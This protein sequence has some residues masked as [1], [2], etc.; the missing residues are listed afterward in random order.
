MSRTAQP[1]LQL[2]PKPSRTNMVCRILSR[3]HVR[4]VLRSLSSSKPQH[5]RCIGKHKRGLPRQSPFSLKK[6]TEIFQKSAEFQ[7]PNKHPPITT[8][9]SRLPRISPQLHH[10]KRPQLSQPPS[11]LGQKQQNPPRKEA[12][13]KSA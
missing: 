7:A 13:K 9:C 12:Q 10:E 5:C 8:T 4:S 11:N 1:L 6:S 3:R 2:L